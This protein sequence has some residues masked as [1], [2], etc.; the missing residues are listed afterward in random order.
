ML[1]PL[2]D[3]CFVAIFNLLLARLSLS[4]GL[5]CRFKTITTAYYRGAMGILLVFDVT[6]RQTFL[7]VKNWMRQIEMHASENVNKILIGNKCD[8][9]EG[10]RDVTTAE[11]GVLA[12]EF[13]VQVFW[14][15]FPSLLQ[16]HP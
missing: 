2:V 14:K 6:N 13:K 11:A 10:E 5:L 12:N 4:C 7:N 3:S 15:L 16:D 1:D 9:G 8:A